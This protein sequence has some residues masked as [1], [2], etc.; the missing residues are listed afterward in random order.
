A[1]FHFRG[2]IL[3]QKFFQVRL[4][5]CGS[6]FKRSNFVNSRR[7]PFEMKMRFDARE[8]VDLSQVPRA[9]LPPA[10]IAI[11]KNP[12]AFLQITSY[13]R[14]QQSIGPSRANSNPVP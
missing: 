8:L 1:I 7:D 14:F 12:P 9:G 5:D 10:R 2:T 6:I 3:W 4:I 13:L 11:E